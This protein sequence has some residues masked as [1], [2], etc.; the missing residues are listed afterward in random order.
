MEVGKMIKLYQFETCPY[1]RKVRQK[2]DKL[3][4]EYEK[5]EVPRD[6]NKRDTIKELSGQVKVPVIQDDDGT[7]VNDSTKIV[8]YLEENYA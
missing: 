1:C 5:I 3:G 4:L 2:L 6:R 7:V 8:N